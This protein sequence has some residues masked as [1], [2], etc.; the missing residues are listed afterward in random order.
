MKNAVL[1]IF[2]CAAALMLAGCSFISYSITASQDA[3][4]TLT[5]TK[6]PEEAFNDIDNVAVLPFQEGTLGSG[7]VWDLVSVRTPFLVQLAD[8]L[9]NKLHEAKTFKVF[10]RK[11]AQN[12]PSIQMVISGLVTQH[13]A[14]V[15]VG[16]NKDGV[17]VGTAHGKLEISYRFVNPADGEVFHSVKL[18][19]QYSKNASGSSYAD[20]KSKLPAENDIRRYLIHGVN[21]EFIHTFT[22]HDVSANYALATVYDDPMFLKSLV[23][24]KIGNW[25][26]GAVIWREY[27]QRNSAEAYYNNMLNI[28]YVEKYLD[29]AI[30]QAKTALDKTGDRTFDLW[31][32]KFEKER[33]RE[34]N[35]R[36]KE[37]KRT[38]APKRFAD[39][40]SEL[41]RVG[42]DERGTIISMDAI[43]FEPGSTTLKSDFQSNLSKIAD[44]LKEYKDFKLVIEGH[45]DNKGSASFNRKLS[46]ERA[47]NVMNY[48]VVEGVS[49]DRMTAVG[50][51][52]E[53]PVA[54]N[55]T[56]EGRAQ[57]RRV[58]LIIQG[59]LPDDVTPP[60]EV[61][62]SEE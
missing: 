34:R 15:D 51:G 59:T 12:E 8:D 41:I 28:R 39:L 56:A 47:A 46:E 57:N 7:S 17:H 33:E 25:E 54:D 11:A 45:T 52:F 20:V 16:V 6:Y 58:E 21:S 61:T 1:L 38:N 35:Y 50:R 10:D 19:K 24:A 42:K 37:F 13:E 18:G 2:L 62:P 40:Q 43:V 49:G 55:K 30:E 31:L 9:Q 26:Q 4:V 60:E 48:L 14:R 27:E 36:K 3:N 32:K 5:Y 29:G 23:A 44:V 22:S 53:K